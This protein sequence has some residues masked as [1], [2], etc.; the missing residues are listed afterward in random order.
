M[1]SPIVVDAGDVDVGEQAHAAPQLDLR[2]DNAIGSDLDELA[3]ARAIGDARGRID[4][5]L[6]LGDDRA[7]FGFGDKSVADLG[8]GSDTTTC[9]G[10]ARSC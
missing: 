4:R 8:L 7:D 9:C 2:P 10:G 6:A 3:N 5:H 1:S